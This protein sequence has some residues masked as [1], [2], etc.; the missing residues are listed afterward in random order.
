MTSF[1]KVSFD[2]LAGKLLEVPASKI[3]L[4]DQVKETA[5]PYS[6]E[7]EIKINNF[8]VRMLSYGL[9]CDKFEATLDDESINEDIVGFS[10]NKF[11]NLYRKINHKYRELER[12]KES[13]DK[14]KEKTREIQALRKKERSLSKLDILEDSK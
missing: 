4:T 13:K 8:K 3:L 10:N 5:G 7:Y 11:L 6:Y 14:I 9:Y 1:R 12:K 2:K